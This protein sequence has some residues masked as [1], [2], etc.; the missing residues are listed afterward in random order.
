MNDF[1]QQYAPRSGQMD[2]SIDQGMRAF[3]M[4]VYSKLAIGIALS[5]ILAFVAGSYAPLTYLLYGTA[6]RWIV[7]LAPAALIMGSMFFMRSASPRGSGILYWAVVVAMGLS[8]GIYFAMAS[9]QVGFAT[10]G[11]MSY[12]AITKAFL[13]TSS[14]FGALSLYGYTTKKDLG[15]VG[16]A[17]IM[18]IWALFAVS[19]VYLILPALLPNVTWLQPGGP[20]E[21]IISG[22]FA[23]LS[24]VIV[25]WQTQSL[26][27]NYRVMAHDNRSLS[28]MTN[29][30]AL[31]FFI[32][33]VNIF[34]FILRLMSSD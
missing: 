2:A 19:I 27:Q 21:W 15:P 26:R 16:A 20:M 22:G 8:M 28:V 12:M 3:M 29:F 31:N 7:M 6:L 33:F 25:A 9:A 13:V 18:G 4:G 32:S 24:A 34:Q 17:A 5:G 10:G 1:N 30:G 14:L 23:L 11:T